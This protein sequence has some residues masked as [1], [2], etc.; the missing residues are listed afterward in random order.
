MYSFSSKLW[1]DKRWISAKTGE[2]SIYLQVTLNGRHKEFPL[3]LRWPVDK[4]DMD[5]GSLLPRRKGDPDR[6]DYNLMIMLEQAKHSD[7]IKTYRLKKK[8]LSLETFTLELKTFNA[9]ENFVTY[10]TEKAMYRYKTKDIAKRTYLNHMAVIAQMK[11]FKTDWPFEELT[12]NWVKKFKQH[13]IVS[14]YE[15][16]GIWTSIKTVKAYLKLAFYE[17]MISIDDTILEFP[18]PE[19][20]WKTVYLTK[21]EVLKLMA[22]PSER[23][24][25]YNE[26]R[27]LNAFL[28]Q[29]FTGLRISDVY[30]ANS[31][32]RLTDG[33]LDFIPKK[34][35]KNKKWVHVP[36]MPICNSFIKNA[37]GT[38]FDLPNE[39]EYNEILKRLAS[40]AGIKKK[41]SSHVGRH[42]YGHLFITSIGNLKALKENM[43]HSKLS[44]TDRYAHLDDEYRTQ[45]IL[46]MQEDFESAIIRKL[47]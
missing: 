44:T 36:I 21:P 28:F 18:N 31:E 2:A 14:K 43:G 3:K 27:V 47:K 17:P 24:L 22:L 32:W 9:K 38:Y 42:T 35:E 26:T 25:T 39:A 4:I 15:P 23:E 45:T 8:P 6:D 30:R 34:N 16:G 10:M 13:L 41:L 20:S 46:K 1:Y 40:F 33:F 7:I 19:P 12:L 11:L 37:L 29:C 5:K